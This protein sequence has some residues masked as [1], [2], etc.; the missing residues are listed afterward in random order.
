[1]DEIL[2]VTLSGD[3]AIEELKKIQKA[4]ETTGNAVGQIGDHAKDFD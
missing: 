1:M 4:A 3:E 2:K